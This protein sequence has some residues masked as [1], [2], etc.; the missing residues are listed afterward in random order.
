[1][2]KSAYPDM[3][4]PA[5]RLPR[6]ED[7]LPGPVS[8][9]KTV[10]TS[11]AKAL[12]RSARLRRL[13][14][15]ELLCRAGEPARAVWL[16]LEGR[17]C[18]NRCAWGG[19]RRNIEIMLPG[20]VF[21]LPSL[22]RGSTPSDITAL[23]DSLLAEIP[24]TAVLRQAGREPLLAREIL[25]LM[26]RRMNFIESMLHLAL[27]SAETRL[28][29]ALW[30]LRHRFGDEIPLSRAEIAQTAGLAP[31]TAMRLLKAF[32]TRG[33]LRRAPDKI[34]IADPTALNAARGPARAFDSS[35]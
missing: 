26:G 29:A 15:G 27:E 31:E 10:P 35:F 12:A 33:I 6:V 18:V 5:A 9:L 11:C 13:K 17:V 14:R 4:P 16:L 3:S 32:E 20:D 22:V 28:A 30:Y 19:Q 34:A 8:L 2:A 23:A 25:L 21:G 1:M 24:S 7:L